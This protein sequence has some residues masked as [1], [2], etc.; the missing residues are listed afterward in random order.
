MKNI[1]ITFSPATNNWI[2]CCTW[3]APKTCKT[4]GEVLDFL[5]TL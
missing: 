5:K 2:V 1:S 4:Y 3:A